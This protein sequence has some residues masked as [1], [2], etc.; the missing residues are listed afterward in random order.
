MGQDHSKDTDI[1][2]PS[3]LENFNSFLQ[4]F[5]PL[6]KENHRVFG[7]IR[8]SNSKESKDSKVMVKEVWFNSEKDARRFQTL[9]K[10]RD[11]PHPF[12]LKLSASY[13]IKEENMCANFI[14]CKF[15]T[16]LPMLTLADVISAKRV[17]F[18][19]NYPERKPRNQK[20]PAQLEECDEFF[21]EPEIWYILDGLV[22][23]AKQFKDAGYSHGAIQ[24]DA[25]FADP[26]GHLS[27]PDVLLYLSPGEAYDLTKGQ[28]ELSELERI[29][30]P[31]SPEVLNLIRSERLERSYETS[32]SEVWSIAI[33]ALCICVNADI[34]EFYDWGAKKIRF[35]LLEKYFEKMAQIGYSS[36]LISVIAKCLEQDPRNRTALDDLNTYLMALESQNQEENESPANQNF[37]QS[38]VGPNYQNYGG[39]S[40]S[41]APS[42]TDAQNYTRGIDK[43]ADYS[44]IL[45]QVHE[46][47]SHRLAAP[48]PSYSSSSLGPSSSNYKTGFN[49]SGANAASSNFGGATTSSDLFLAPKYTHLDTF[50]PSIPK[51]DLPYSEISNVPLGLNSSLAY[52][53]PGVSNAPSD[54]KLSSH[55]GGLASSNFT[56]APPGQ[57]FSSIGS[58]SLTFGGAS[59]SIPA[60]T[61]YGVSAHSYHPV[62]H[63]S[64]KPDRQF[65]LRNSTLTKTIGETP[66]QPQDSLIQESTKH[67][68]LGI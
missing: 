28:I 52:S 38:N 49:Y 15:A 2:D 58:S 17:K 29:K 39:N 12:L 46:V 22:G 7:V 36:D 50:A 32:K 8:C 5:E 34:E 61:H 68:A 54:F 25:I 21:S 63:F 20:V 26:E 37:E 65:E 45:P 67:R 33:T 16:E 47:S 6:K 18:A 48:A 19:A 23:V 4:G 30:A 62:S 9:L 11:F 41:G 10:A 51:T 40:Y 53:T 35:N 1:T 27:L 66:D 64:N 24:P 57:A 56:F 31:I 42:Y 44:P 3:R 60:S 59:S 55:V 14:R 43:F 13:A